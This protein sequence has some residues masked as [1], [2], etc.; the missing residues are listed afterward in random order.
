M[1]NSTTKTKELI[2]K[3]SLHANVERLDTS[4]IRFVRWLLVSLLVMVTGISFFGVQRWPLLGHPFLSHET[5]E[6]MIVF[7][8]SIVSGLTAFVLSVPGNERFDQKRFV[9]SL[10]LLWP[11][12]LGLAIFHTNTLSFDQAWHLGC[13]WQILTYSLPPI[14]FFY[15]CFAKQ[16]LLHLCGQ[17]FWDP[18]VPWGWDVWASSGL[19]SEDKLFI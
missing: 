17:L 2:E 16:L 3:L 9:I 10:L 15:G 12:L 7:S 1:E 6:S 8:L 4:A 13:A 19:V 11:L 5:L 18:S 14:S